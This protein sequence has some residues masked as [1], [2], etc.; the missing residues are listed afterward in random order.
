MWTDKGDIKGPFEK[1]HGIL[2]KY[3]CTDEDVLSLQNMWNEPHRVYHNQEH[4]DEIISLI[5]HWK[6]TH[7]TLTDT[8]FDLYILTAIFHD[9]IYDPK[10]NENELRS[11]ELFAKMCPKASDI[12]TLDINNGGP[13]IYSVSDIVYGMILDTK[14]HTQKPTSFYSETFLAFDL[15]GM[16]F[17]SLSRMISDEKKIMREF[18]FVDYDVYHN[19]RGTKFLEKFAPHIK[20]AINPNSRVDE[21]LDWYKTQTPKIA[22]FAG[23]FFPF[24]KGHLDILKRAERVFDKVIVLVC[25]NPG[26]NNSTSDVANYVINDLQKKL[27][28]NQVEFYTGM[29]HNYIKSKNYPLSVIKGLRNASDFD[30]EKLQLRYMEDMLPDINIVYIVSDRKYEHVSSSGIKQIQYMGAIDEANEYLP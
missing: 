29:L 10:S 16:S 14:D 22:V 4:L 25:V 9:A 18:G 5:E 11:G 28:N 23:T 6:V 27:P 7:P 12:K 8:E 1:Y 30:S 2:T 24:H 13:I 21:Y 17:G 3:G 20:K 26:K 19:T 15:N